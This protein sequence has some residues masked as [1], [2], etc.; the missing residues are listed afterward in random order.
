MR[1]V[2]AYAGAA[3][4]VVQR[5]AVIFTTYRFTF[6]TQLASTLFSIVL[7]YYISRLVTVG[8]F[9]SPDQYFAFAVI[10]VVTLEVVNTAAV[11]VPN[12]LRGELVMGTFE[13]LVLSP[14]G[15]VASAASMMLFPFAWVVFKTTI[16]LLIAAVAFD[17]PLQWPGAALAVPIA[18]LG[19][20]SFAPFGLLVT[21]VVLVAKQAMGMTT[22]IVAALSIV[23]GFYFPVT[24]LPDW[25]EW[26]SEVQPFTP[27]I[28]LMRSTL[29]GIEMSESAWLAAAKLVGFTAVLLPIAVWAV[30]RAVRVSRRRGT[31]IEY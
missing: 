20:L 18:V 25:I 28:E 6:F 10:G 2:A 21:A 3:A 22:W 1:R 30:G 27:T 16:A 9:S 4:G 29:V 13:R 19:A 31:I 8:E 11:L 23:A 12:T 14:F 26:F 24:L 15:A 17:L 7:F 5:D